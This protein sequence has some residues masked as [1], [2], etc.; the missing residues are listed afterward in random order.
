MSLSIIGIHNVCHN[1]WR[2]SWQFGSRCHIR[3]DRQ[4]TSPGNCGC[5]FYWR[6]YRSSCMSWG[7]EYGASSLYLQFI[8]L[9]TSDRWTFFN[10]CW[11]RL[12]IMCLPGIHSGTL[13][14]KNERQN[15]CPQVC[16]IHVSR[17]LIG[18]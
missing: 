3:L 7:L 10:R 13:T 14:N 12:C 9:I 15:G 5:Y 17:H 16:L 8:V 1:T 4:E 11:G 2:P 6:C 18:I